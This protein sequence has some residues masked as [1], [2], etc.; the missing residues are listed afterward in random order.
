MNVEEYAAKPILAAAGIA[1]P[2]GRLCRDA[3]EARK[4]AEAIGP[5]V[6]KAQVPTGKRGKAGGIKLVASP[7]ETEEAA[8]AVL[9]MTIGGHVVEKVLVEAQAS[10]D[11]EFY[12]AVLN[13]QETKGPLLLFS[14]EGGMDV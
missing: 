9:G 8:A 1:V 5:A 2:P 10:I 14:T 13:H 6:V 12:A 3:A 4:A 11:R 7:R